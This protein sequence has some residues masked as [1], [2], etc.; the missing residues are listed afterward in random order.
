MKYAKIMIILVM[1]IFIL[2]VAGASA[3]DADDL[4]IKSDNIEKI[5]V[6]H[7]EI[8]PANDELIGDAVN[9]TFHDLENK[10]KSGYGSSITLDMDYT[11]NGAEYEEGIPITDSITIDGKGH[12][13]DA[14]EASRIFSI[15]NDEANVVLINIAFI[16]G[17]YGVLLVPDAL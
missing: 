7:S 13:I 16:N 5:S 6:D 12:T 2:S 11:S 10:I 14:N 15:D 8:G 1:A 17:R 9:G 3:S 4:A